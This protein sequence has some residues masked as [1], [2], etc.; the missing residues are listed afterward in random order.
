MDGDNGSVPVNWEEVAGDIGHAMAQ[1]GWLLGQVIKL[2]CLFFANAA[3]SLWRA[4]G[5]ADCFCNG[6]FFP[7]GVGDRSHNFACNAV[8][9]RF[10]LGR[11]VGDDNGAEAIHGDRQLLRQ[12][13]KILLEV[14]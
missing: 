12:V 2:P 4:S 13:V 9:G 8:D 5:D 11:Q 14:F 10:L 6:L 1:A 7:S 3:Y